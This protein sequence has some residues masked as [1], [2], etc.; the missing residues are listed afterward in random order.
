MGWRRIAID[1]AAA[2]LAAAFTLI[3]LQEGGLGAGQPGYRPL[4]VLGVLL[5]LGSTLPLCFQTRAPELAF[6]LSAAGTLTLITLHYPVDVP[7]G[8]LVVTFVLADTVDPESILRRRL[9]IAAVSA[10][11]PVAIGLMVL[12]DLKI[13]GMASGF[14][15]WAAMF[16][17]VWLAGDR[18]RLRRDRIT[19]LVVTARLRD[20]DLQAQR[21][22]AAAE[23]RTRIARELH[24]SAGHAINVILVQAGAARLLQERDPEGSRRA[25][26]T[27]EEVAHTTI[28]DIDRLVRAL[29]HG[30]G[31]ADPA[32]TD[33]AALEQLVERHRASGLQV[34]T[35]FHG[36]PRGL[37]SSVA[38]AAYRILQEALTNA[39]RHG[40]GR[41]DV[42]MSYGPS[43]VDIEVTNPIGADRHPSRPASSRAD[44]LGDG[45]VLDSSRRDSARRDSTHRDTA[46]GTLMIKAEIQGGAEGRE[47][48]GER[49]SS[50][51]GRMTVDEVLDDAGGDER[52]RHTDT[53][54]LDSNSGRAGVLAGLAGA[55]E[56]DLDHGLTRPIPGGR[57]PTVGGAAPA[58]VTDVRLRSGLGIV[59]MRERVALL[60]G[61]LVTGTADAPDGEVFRLRAHLPYAAPFGPG[62]PL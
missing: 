54:V 6:G 21:R 25:I 15:A 55:N 62:V 33:T 28:A 39:A 26:E 40:S 38:W 35:T 18:N 52:P 43:A 8:T 31:P 46:E 3:M 5:T 32:P 14:A 36:A 29:R 27:V 47:R 23:E 37:P 34:E 7:P 2:L 48:A 17:L 16:A 57:R 60:D 61:S 51:A 11:V 58:D 24:D 53:A 42:W 12:N 10:Y 41:A 9:A 59:G 4:D 45:A 19:E 50:A 30:S 56:I 13:H 49:S 20:L 44:A 22:L 1:C